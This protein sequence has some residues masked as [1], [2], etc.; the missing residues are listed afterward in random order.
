[1]EI[2]NFEFNE[3][4]RTLLGTHNMGKDWPVVYIIHNGTD[5]YIGE[6]TSAYTRS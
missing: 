3:A 5:L 2:K 6:T 4:G 1:M